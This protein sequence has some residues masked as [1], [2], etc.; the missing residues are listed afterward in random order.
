MLLLHNVLLLYKKSALFANIFEHFALSQYKATGINA[1][2][3]I[4][5][6]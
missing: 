5:A 1:Y 3:H 6:A 4:I 2:V